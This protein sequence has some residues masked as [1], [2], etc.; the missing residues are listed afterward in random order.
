MDGDKAPMGGMGVGFATKFGSIS[1]KCEM[2]FI[3][4]KIRNIFL[5][6]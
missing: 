5:V 6:L 3:W 4:S 2:S 1:N